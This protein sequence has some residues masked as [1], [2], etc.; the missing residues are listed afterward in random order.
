MA[1]LQVLAE[2]S[3]VLFVSCEPE[4]ASW[5]SVRGLAHEGSKHCG[6]VGPGSEGTLLGNTGP[7]RSP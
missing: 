3:A 6:S 2:F 1:L 5:P 4:H 7:C